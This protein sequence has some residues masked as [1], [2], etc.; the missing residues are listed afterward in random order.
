M[1]SDSDFDEEITDVYL[2][3]KVSNYETIQLLWE[4]LVEIFF[5]DWHFLFAYMPQLMMDR[6][7]GDD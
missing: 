2:E 4:I 6:C 3:R 1:T 7:G 5:E